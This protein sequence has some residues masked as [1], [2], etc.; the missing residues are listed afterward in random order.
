M[1]AGVRPDPAIDP[2]RGTVHLWS[3]NAVLPTR[4]QACLRRDTPLKV[5]DNGWAASNEPMDYYIVSSLSATVEREAARHNAIPVVLPAATV[6]L[7]AKL[8]EITAAGKDVSICV[9]KAP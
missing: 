7:A 9:R 3:R 6:W 8:D 2:K 4:I 1:T 5:R